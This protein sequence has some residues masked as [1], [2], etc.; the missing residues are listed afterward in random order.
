VKH[1]MDDKSSCL[2]LVGQMQSRNTF[3][4]TRGTNPPFGARIPHDR[5]LETNFRIPA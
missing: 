3:S 2:Q 4:C 1:D 5:E